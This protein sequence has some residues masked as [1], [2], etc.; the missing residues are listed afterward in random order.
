VQLQG[1]ERAEGFF[2]GNPT[3]KRSKIR[4]MQYPAIHITTLL[5]IRLERDQNI[6]R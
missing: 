1:K 4:S 6:S 2:V 5:Y 3:E